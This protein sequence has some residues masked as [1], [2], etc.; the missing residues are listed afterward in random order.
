MTAHLAME[1][2]PVKQVN[3]QKAL[4]GIS[5]KNLQYTQPR[6][7]DHH[8]TFSFHLKQKNIPQLFFPTFNFQISK[9]T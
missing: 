2:R 8:Q 9:H 5:Y 4:N 7:T 3:E 6:W 1:H